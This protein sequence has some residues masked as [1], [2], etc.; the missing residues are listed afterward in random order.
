MEQ[1]NWYAC[2]VSI[3]AINNTPVKQIEMTIL[4]ILSLMRPGR[5]LIAQTH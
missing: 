3:E 1:I 2:T 5:S 4:I